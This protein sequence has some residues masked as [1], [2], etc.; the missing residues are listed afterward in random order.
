[1]AGSE[2][3]YLRSDG[4]AE[5]PS[6]LFAVKMLVRGQNYGNGRR[7]LRFRTSFYA[8]PTIVEWNAE[9][10]F[11]L[12]PA[13]LATAL[14][15]RGYAK[16]VSKDV[17]DAYNDFVEGSSK[18]SPAP[19]ETEEVGDEDEDG[20]EPKPKRSRRRRKSETEEN[21]DG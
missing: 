12:Y 15:T 9:D 17:V 1:M 3:L 6:G 10:D 8:D 4:I 16:S 19:K 14:V 18:S 13:A 2:K 5:T 7:Q 21:D 20:A 11:A